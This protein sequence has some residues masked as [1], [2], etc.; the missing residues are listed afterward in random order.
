MS[1]EE[2][3][4]EGVRHASALN[5]TPL[6]ALPFRFP[7]GACARAAVAGSDHRRALAFPCAQAWH[8][9][10]DVGPYGGS[11]ATTEGR[12]VSAVVEFVVGQR[13]HIRARLEVPGRWIFY[14]PRRWFEVRD[15]LQAAQ[16]DGVG[17]GVV[18]FA[19]SFCI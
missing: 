16:Y 18:T 2:G 12:I 8:E 3:V 6:L 15:E 19:A 14:E 5:R 11:L 4:D 13:R 1:V 17:C 9:A 7:V 10:A